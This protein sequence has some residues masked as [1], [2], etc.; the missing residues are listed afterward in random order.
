[1]EGGMDDERLTGEEPES[2]DGPN[3]SRSVGFG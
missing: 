2:S 3:I 1:M